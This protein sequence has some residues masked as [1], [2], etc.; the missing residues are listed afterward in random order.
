MELFGDDFFF[1]NNDDTLYVSV[2]GE[3]FQ[4]SQLLSIYKQTKLLGQGGFGKVYQAEHERTGAFAAIK[5]INVSD[6]AGRANLID[7]IF[8]ESKTLRMLKHKNIIQ[9]Y[10]TL[11]LN[12]NLVM[13]MEFAGG[14]EL[15]TYVE[16]CEGLEEEEVRDFTEQ[17]CGAIKVCHQKGIIHR[18]L[19]LENVLFH[20][21]NR[22]VLKVCDFGIAGRCR[23]ESRDNN[24][25]GTLCYLPPEVLLDPHSTAAPQQDIWAI[26]V[27][28]YAM[29]FN[30]LP[31]DG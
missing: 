2:S 6:A 27:M 29:L 4:Y 3:D 14:G 21:E 20:S 9:L 28:M 31:F 24:N 1:M 19:K 25:G 13:I 22:R 5:Y 12:N 8:M 23:G 11:M 16:E 7:D 30:Q 18:D 17:L 10:H 26:G 15:K